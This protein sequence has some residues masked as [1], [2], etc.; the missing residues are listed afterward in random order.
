MKNLILTLSLIILGGCSSMNYQKTVSKLE[1]DKFMGKW[2]V[3]AGRYTFLEKGAHNAV[4]KYTWNEKESRIDVD[5]TFNKDSFDG[6]LKSISQKAWIHDKNSNAHWKISLFWPIKLSYLVIGLAD[7]YSWTAVGVPD[8][9]YLWIMSR[10]SKMDEATLQDILK[11]LKV[12]GYPVEDIV[13]TPQQW[14]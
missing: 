2:Y 6:K 5:F 8:G 12:S 4:E 14:K 13:K 11:Q 10:K 3:I 1:V 7:D 9:K